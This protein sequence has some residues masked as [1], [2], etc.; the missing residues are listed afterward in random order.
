[1]RALYGLTSGRSKP[2]HANVAP[3]S[4]SGVW[5]PSEHTIVLAGVVIAFVLVASAL[6]VKRDVWID[7]L[8][9][10]RT[11]VS[12]MAVAGLVVGI[13]FVAAAHLD[14][15]EELVR[16]VES[17]DPTWL[18]LAVGLEVVSFGGYVVLTKL[19]YRPRAPRLGWI[20]SLELT[21]AG[22]VATRLF[23][24]GGA[25]G[26]AFTGWVLHRAGMDARTAARRLSAFMLLLYSV[27]VAALLLGGL[28]VLLDALGDV[29]TLLGAIALGVALASIV[30]AVLM[31]RIPGD[32]E[33]RAEALAARHA[34]GALGRL[35]TR[36]STVPQVAGNATR[37]ALAIVGERPAAMLWPIV[38]WAFDVAT[39]W[40]CFE[41]FGDAPAIGTL[42]LCYFL[43][44]MGNLLPIPGGVGGTEGGMVGAF[45]ASGVD[46]G[47]ALVAVVAYQLIST[48]LP[49]LPGLLSYIDLR[50]RMKTWE[51]AP[52]PSAVTAGS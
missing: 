27:Y 48:Y 38:W 50:R 31:V 3:M 19:V 6:V 37:L 35:A 11:L 52:E 2:R 13:A 7:G 44:A 8:R 12:R 16:R 18:A 24:A 9:E 32:V 10:H 22:V 40:A 23:S 42:I 15:L 45:A 47:L 14:D 20:A 41:A 51:A 21:L 29:P 34:G 30:V 5:L 17:G 43:G 33:R 28:L 46:A 49:A 26:I 4:P 25:G 36:L 1:M 39:L